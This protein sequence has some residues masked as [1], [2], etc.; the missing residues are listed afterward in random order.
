MQYLPRAWGGGG[1]RGLGGSCGGRVK[2]IHQSGQKGLG[3]T[4]TWALGVEHDLIIQRR[5]ACAHCDQRAC[6][7]RLRPQI[8]IT[9]V[10]AHGLTPSPPHPPPPSRLLQLVTL[11]P[12]THAFSCSFLF[13]INSDRR[14][15][16]RSPRCFSFGKAG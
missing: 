15:R 6:S 13:G 9:L 1:R 7:C 3:E 4:K 10:P 8:T 16:E 5:V 12:S 2:P 14:G 11:S